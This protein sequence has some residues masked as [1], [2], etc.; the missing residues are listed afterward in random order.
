MAVAACSH[1]S[2]GDVEVQA[3]LGADEVTG[4]ELAS[5]PQLQRAAQA[6][7]PN[8]SSW[9]VTR[10]LSVLDLGTQEGR[11]IG[12]CTSFGFLRDS[13][14]RVR[15]RP[16][17]PVGGKSGRQCSHRTLY[18]LQP[19]A[20]QGAIPAPRGR[21]LMRRLRS[22]VTGASATM[23]TNFRSICFVKEHP[24]DSPMRAPILT[25]TPCR[26]PGTRTPAS[27]ASRLFVSSIAL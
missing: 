1:C 15:C 11:A 16:R 4:D 2:R 17:E 25:P 22:V 8:D 6:E 20:V 27:E 19:T 14:H 12:S 13:A 10:F 9:F 7:F 21:G 18:A 24:P 23:H 26:K 3:I 5:G